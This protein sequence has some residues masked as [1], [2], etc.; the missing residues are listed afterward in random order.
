MSQKKDRH[1]WFKETYEKELNRTSN[2]ALAL[3][4]AERESFRRGRKNVSQTASYDISDTKDWD[5]KYAADK[6]FRNK[7]RTA[8]LAR[9]AKRTKKRPPRMDS[10]SL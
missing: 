3:K 4:A 8:A 1:D 7:A 6:A 5:S 9:V 2:S 10:K